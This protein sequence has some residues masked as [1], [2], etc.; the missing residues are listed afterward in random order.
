MAD[1][2]QTT[3]LTPLNEPTKQSCISGLWSSAKTL[4]MGSK[5]NILL[6]AIPFAILFDVLDVTSA[7]FVFSLI[8]LIPLAE[9]NLALLSM[10]EYVAFSVLD[11]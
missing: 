9:V 7:T 4:A 10:N 5:L 2:S 8:G 3:L 1:S 6:V 11:L